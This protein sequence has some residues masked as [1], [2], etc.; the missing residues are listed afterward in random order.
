MTT[1]P[2]FIDYLVS[3]APEGETALIVRQKI[4]TRNGKP[5]QYRDGTMKAVWTPYLPGRKF[6][7]E[8]AVYGNTGSFIESRLDE[9][10]L[11]ASSANCEYVM[12]MVLDDV[13]DPDKAP[14]IPALEPTWKIE[15]SPNS[16]Q[17][18]YAFADG[19]QPTK[20]DFTNAIRAIADAGYTD[21]GACNP[22]RNFRVPGS[23]NLKP[24]KNYFKS[25]MVEF[26]PDREFT[27]SQICEALG[28][29]PDSRNSRTVRPV[30][31][32]DAQ[33]DTVLAWL[34]E[35]GLVLGPVNR[36]GW[37][38][39]V[40]PNHQNH[41]TPEDLM[42]RYHPGDRAFVCYH[43]HC[44][45]FTSQ[46][47][48]DWVADNG[49]PSVTHGLRTELLSDTLSVALKN[50]TP[51]EMFTTDTDAIIAEVQN[52]ELGRITKQGWYQR[53]AYVISEDGYFDLEYRNLV[54]RKS[55]NAV[56]RHIEC[57]GLHSGRKVEA[58]VCY[59]EN[60]ES[61]RAKMVAGQTYAAGE[62]VIVA[63]DGELYGNR[64]R[65]ARPVVDKSHVADISLWLQHAERLIP[66]PEEREH[67]FNVMAYKLQHPE[68]KIN[69]AVL[70]VGREGCGK[71][72][73][74][75]PFIWA[76]CGP[77]L[78][79]RGLVDNENISGNFGYQ[80]ESE[81][82]ILNELKEPNAADRRAL[83]NKL[84]PIIAAP[85][86]TISIN[87]KNQHPY[88]MLNRVFVLAFSNDKVPL[89]LPSQDRRWFCLKSTAGRMPVG[90]AEFMWKWYNTGGFEAIAAWLYRRD[91]SMFNPAA[92]PMAT[93]FKM[94]MVEHGMSSSESYLVDMIRNG[95]GEFARGVVGSPFFSLCDRLSGMAPQGM[96]V[97]QVALLHALEE[98]GWVDMGKLKSS[99]YQ[100][101]KSVYCSPEMAETHSRSEL[102]DMLE[103]PPESTLLRKV[104]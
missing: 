62:S 28:V 44:E 77:H 88:D 17:W 60:R 43:G 8:W 96:K 25:R 53:F 58:S 104:K 42:A 67:V 46:M 91:V 45:E 55:F 102:R 34:N 23:V 94:T 83:A 38:A 19:E 57:K 98:S 20:M 48:L 30:R 4:I 100:T 74:W 90:E 70:H 54:P 35:Q 26:H 69:H 89:S 84:K 2:Q 93:D 47:F 36:E 11:S 92:P 95:F 21:P 33:D 6:N 79:N 1:Q 82:M 66:E 22:V 13:G 64:W 56:F 85:P 39:V 18:G 75:G 29:S 37:C 31:L 3:L 68:K 97:S 15:T 27:L 65:D 103:L 71:D 32:N 14:N 9:N 59:D 78:R 99:R 87:K 101:K 40:C 86:E 63:R 41:T 73:L 80:L 50:L 10:K 12:V 76:V 51:S 61:N 72:T 24:G 5:E 16:F 49:G 52:R 7:E 81:I